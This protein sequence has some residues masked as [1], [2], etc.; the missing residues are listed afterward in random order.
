MHRG[1][2]EYFALKR[3]LTDEAKR[4]LESMPR[5]VS[6]HFIQPSLR[7][8]TEG[9][10]YVY[11]WCDNGSNIL[12]YGCNSNGDAVC[13][14]PIIDPGLF[15]L[16]S[17]L[18]VLQE[19][20]ALYGCRI[21]VF[22][23]ITYKCNNFAV[24]DLF[25]DYEV[26]QRPCYLVK[27][28]TKTVL[29][30][31]RIYSKFKYNNRSYRYVSVQQYFDVTKNILFE[32]MVKR[33]EALPPNQPLTDYSVPETVM[34]WFDD[35]LN[36]YPHFKA[37]EIPIIVF[38]IE[39]VS[40]DPHRVPTGDHPKDILFT[41]SIY[42]TNTNTL[43]TLVFLPLNERPKDLLKRIL[44][45][46]YETVPDK[47]VDDSQ[48]KNVLEVFTTELGLLKRTMELLTMAPKL[49][50]LYGYN[51]VN[52]DIKYLLA[53]CVFYRHETKRFVWREGFCFGI[54]QMHLD[55]F[56]IIIMRY[57][58]K[59]YT[60]N[61]VSMEIMK[62]SKTGVSAV[63]LRYTFFRMLK[64]QRY[65]THEESSDKMPSI[66]DTLHYNNADTLLVNKLELKT[67]S[68]P[69]VIQ[70]AQAC[71]V[72]LCTMTTNYDT[73][74]FK[75]W[76]QCF[77]VGLGMGL[78]LATFR[79]STAV[80]KMPLSSQYSADD[81]IDLKH[82]LGTK[83]NMA[84]TTAEKQQ[85]GI[86]A[87]QA[88]G[89]SGNY[90]KVSKK[91][92]KFPGGA[93][94]CLGEYDVDNVQMYDY[95]TAYPVL[96]VRKNISDETTTIM[97]A[98]M[99]R[100]A[101]PKIKNK[102]E[103]RTYDYLAH[104]GSTKME[105]VIIYYQYIYDGLYCGGEFAFTEEELFKRNDSLVIIIWEFGRRGILSLIVDQFNKTR[106]RTKVMRNTC[107]EAYTM[108]QERINELENQQRMLEELEQE[109]AEGGDECGGGGGAGDG[110]EC[111]GGDDG[112]QIEDDFVA[113]DGFFGGDDFDD[114]GDDGNNI[115]ID[116]DEVP[117]KISK[118]DS[119]TENKNNDD[120][121]GD[122]DDELFGVDEDE[123]TDKPVESDENE[124]GN[125]GF[126]DD[127]AD[128]EV[129]ATAATTTG[130][131]CDFGDDVDFGENDDD[132]GGD[133]DFVDKAKSDAPTTDPNSS[134]TTKNI[135]EPT[136][137]PKTENRKQ[138]T[139]HFGFDFVNEYIDVHDN[140]VCVIDEDLLATHTLELQI[141]ILTAIRDAIAIEL[142]KISN[143]YDLQKAKVSSI[144]GCIGQLIFVVAAAITCMTRNALLASA[145]Y[146]RRMG[147][148]IL[149]IDTDS[150]MTIGGRENLSG[151]LNDLY[152]YMEMEMKVA[153]QCKFV[154]RKTYYK[155]E[156]GALKYG[157]HV[158]GPNSWR[159]FVNYFQNQS[160]LETNDDVHKSFY[161]FFMKTY[162]KLKK[163]TDISSDL[164][165]QITQVI[166]LKSEYTTSTVPAK[167][168]Q[169][170]CEKYPA[171]AGSRKHTVFYY[172]ESSVLLPSLRPDIDLT[173]I[174]DLRYVN[175][176]KYYQ[177]M[178]TTV[179][180]LIKF[181]LRKNNEPFNITV[182]SK[183]VQLLMLRGFLD[184]YQ[185]TFE[186]VVNLDITAREH[187]MNG[188]RGDDIL[189]NGSEPEAVFCDPL[190]EQT[191][192]HTVAD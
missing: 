118:L 53:R 115:S 97:P 165:K 139:N 35:R 47:G 142:T 119:G 171:I 111:G 140:L 88:Q 16:S 191:Y 189:A 113:D 9:L 71:Q 18:D 27:I 46:G 185:S 125:F 174:N 79:D 138:P 41:T 45:D 5:E 167:F 98:S 150:I 163:F 4:K 31:N 63:N 87:V 84:N 106:A 134:A 51:S 61:N 186:R 50:F 72:P 175:L 112:P 26:S 65:F 137:A 176:F 66:R 38:D 147:R 149:Y 154:K 135:N 15:V 101:Y 56:R 20:C 92:S 64:Y 180:N 94:F 95:V 23:K 143:S 11:E 76:N 126:M 7:T 172:M 33:C 152:P 102:H 73:M 127:D 12:G 183:S 54:E 58:F 34:L 77:V 146:C 168:K 86:Q 179:F 124:D 90:S 100:M 178:F 62:D 141:I 3:Q 55:L 136:A 117:A 40:D 91:K 2:Q 187:T 82:D 164:L 110:N 130:D 107:D 78:F 75:M 177:N 190:Y 109:M 32:L 144:Y 105:T 156:D 145:Q 114:F 192:E 21:T 57:R 8:T 30:A 85:H 69:F 48:C 133:D 123:T 103:F 52:Y 43:Y 80:M 49:H 39:T 89:F 161:N 155:L 25:S 10:T 120:L 128:D 42:H 13:I 68:I 170:L 159:E 28:T 108:V 166:N 173:S 36:T 122:D 184:A 132:F 99:L 59:S 22:K 24:W 37:P 116:D 14:K 74:Q 104:S 162:E 121:F 129:A 93:N 83:L 19:V 181:H 169:Y 70:L 160:H 29:E 44:D 157:Q 151:Q 67:K 182:S 1:G 188:A 17:E 6:G 96:M 153:R 148:E 60:L 158:N 131:D 81:F